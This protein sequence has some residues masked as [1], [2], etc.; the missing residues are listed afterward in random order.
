M[1]AASTFCRFSGVS[2]ISR[3]LPGVLPAGVPTDRQT[4]RHQKGSVK[5]QYAAAWNLLTWRPP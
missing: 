3:P 1:A 4:D 2:P 5:N